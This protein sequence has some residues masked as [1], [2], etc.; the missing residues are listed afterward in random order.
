MPK[1]LDHWTTRA[2][3]FLLSVIVKLWLLC[4]LLLSLYCL[5][6]VCIHYCTCICI[7]DVAL[8]DWLTNWA[9]VLSVNW[10]IYI[11]LWYSYVA[12]HTDVWIYRATVLVWWANGSETSMSAV[13]CS[14]CARHCVLWCSQNWR[15]CQQACHRNEFCARTRV[16][17]FVLHRL[18]ICYLWQSKYCKTVFAR[19]M[20]SICQSLFVCLSVCLSVCTSYWWPCVD[21]FHHRLFITINDMY[22][23]CLKKT[24][25]PLACYNLDIHS[26]ITIIFGTSVTE[27]VGNQ[28]LLYFPTSPN[29]C[30]CTTWW[31]RK[32][33]NCTF[34]LK[35]CMLFTKDTQN[36]LKYHL[37]TAKPPF[38]V[39]T[40]D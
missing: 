35:C 23:P 27:K 12:G 18:V 17:Y 40:I 28:N 29:L 39:K 1:W 16:F 10:S 32:P 2:A 20:L 21:V 8:F 15:N 31:N 26:S 9:A 7:D 34:S 37:V 5:F 4:T 14:H 11:L 38:T 6:A 3:I 25:P 33:E 13:C 22:T 36:T 19:H 30:F 24:V